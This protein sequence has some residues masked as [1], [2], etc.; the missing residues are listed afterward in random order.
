MAKDLKFFMRERKE[1]IITAPGPDS[2]LGENG[3]PIGLEIKVLTGTE[4][5][6]IEDSYR[7]R[8]IA[9]NEKGAPYISGGEVLFKTEKDSLRATR[10]IIAEALVYPNLKDPKLMEFY[11]CV[12][13]TEMPRL[14]FHRADEYTHVLKAVFIALGLS[15]APSDD[16][17]LEDAKN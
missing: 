10:H 3:K 8:S 15:E 17:T 16:K 7:K 13:M 4:I 14:V 2:I 11:N 5:Q 12:D 9:V 1:E 6:K